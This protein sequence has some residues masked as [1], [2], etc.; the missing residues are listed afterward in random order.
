MNAPTQE[1]PD[2]GGSLDPVVTTAAVSSAVAVVAGVTSDATSGVLHVVFGVLMVVTGLYALYTIGVLVIWFG[3]SRMVNNVVQPKRAS[4]AVDDRL[5]WFV[6]VG[7][8][9]LIGAW[10]L[11]AW[12]SGYDHAEWLWSGASVV[13]ASVVVL[14]VYFRGRSGS[15]Q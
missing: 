11:S 4:R 7:A 1:H 3:L 15:R 14:A 12:M 2:E 13:S 5:P 8:P 10:A 6:W 9:L